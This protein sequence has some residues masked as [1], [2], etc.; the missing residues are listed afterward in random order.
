MAT[1]PFG[2]GGGFSAQF[3]RSD[4]TWQNA[5]VEEY[6]K[7][8]PKGEKFPPTYSFPTTGRG[9]PDVAALGEGFQVVY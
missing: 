6:F 1:D 4:A 7:I 2:S 9:T 3:N 8:A 5:A